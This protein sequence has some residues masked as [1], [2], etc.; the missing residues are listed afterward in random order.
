MTFNTA[1]ATLVFGSRVDMDV[2]FVSSAIF[3]EHAHIYQTPG[4]I[5]VFTMHRETGAAANVGVTYEFA[6]SI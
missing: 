3:E 1:K 4:D 5:F 6:R 2:P